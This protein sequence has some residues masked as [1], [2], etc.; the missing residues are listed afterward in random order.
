MPMLTLSPRSLGSHDGAYRE[1]DNG[2]HMVL[3]NG[4]DAVECLIPAGSLEEILSNPSTE[5]L[6][7]IVQLQKES[8]EVGH[9]D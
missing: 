6:Y 8:L 4:G 3:V 1:W 9:E 5:G 7:H 2:L